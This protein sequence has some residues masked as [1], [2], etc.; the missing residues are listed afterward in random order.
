MKDYPY[1]VLAAAISQRIAF[2]ESLNIGSTVL[3]TS[4]KSLAASEIN[5]VVDELL[6]TIEQERH[7]TEKTIKA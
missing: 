6:Q 4:A 3:E 7:A 1:P 5:A 2:A